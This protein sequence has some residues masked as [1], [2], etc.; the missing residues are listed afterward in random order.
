MN[1]ISP[2]LCGAGLAAWKPKLFKTRRVARDAPGA[3]HS[4]AI[5]TIAKAGL[6]RCQPDVS[7]CTLGATIAATSGTR[8]DQI[9]DQVDDRAQ[10]PV[11]PSA[12]QVVTPS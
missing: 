3:S 4:P 11:R 12:D 10:D 1:S 9:G 7:H 5:S 6:S 8:N 2:T